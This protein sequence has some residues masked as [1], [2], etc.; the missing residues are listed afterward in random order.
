MPSP[1]NPLLKQF[2]DTSKKPTVVL[3]KVERHLLR[4]QSERDYSYLHPSD[5]VNPKWCVREAWFLLNGREKITDPL[6][7][8]LASIFAE[9]HTIHDKW[10]GWFTEMD[11]LIGAWECQVHKDKWWGKRSHAH[12]DCAVKY[13]EVPVFDSPGL[14]Q[15]RGDG[16]LDLDT[17]QYFLEIKSIGTGTIRVAGGKI[18]PGGLEKTFSFINAPFRT[19]V[20][21]VMFYLWLLHCMFEEG[22]LH[23][24]PPEKALLLYECKADQAVKEFVVDYDLEWLEPVFD[25][26]NSF[27]P[28]SRIPP[29]CS[30]DNAECPACKGYV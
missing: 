1:A 7:L 6:S 5:I 9:G 10:Q 11:V 21:Q 3:G 29:P 19:H 4:Q 8:R 20:R 28:E 16:W 17:G 2:L 25:R 24:A 26:L 27:D 23:Q 22:L 13:L 15:G 30:T 14:I 18:D 12:Q